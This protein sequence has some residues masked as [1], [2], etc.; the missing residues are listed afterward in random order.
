MTHGDAKRS[1]QLGRIL[2]QGGAQGN[3]TQ[4]TENT[5]QF[6]EKLKT[7]IRNTYN[8]KAII[9]GPPACA[10]AMQIDLTEQR[11][12]SKG[13]G[14]PSHGGRVLPPALQKEITEAMARTFKPVLMFN[15]QGE[16][17]PCASNNIRPIYESQGHA[18][19][20]TTPAIPSL[21]GYIGQA[22]I[23]ERR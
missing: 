11:N 1:A 14:H 6:T 3:S 12:K 13:H 20:A 23:E 21:E 22:Q 8:I 7:D 16:H 15:G 17:N 9:L 4:T 2:H 19:D 5:V 10:M 18:G